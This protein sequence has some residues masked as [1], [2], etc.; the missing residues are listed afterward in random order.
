MRDARHRGGKAVRE[1]QA[2]A[3]LRSLF[4]SQRLAVL[5]TQRDGR[6]YGSLV[7]FEVSDDLK[8]LVFATARTTRK[9]ANLLADPWVALVIDSR[10]NRESDFREAV[11]VTATGLSREVF[12][13]EREALAGRYLAKHPA[14]REFV[15]SPTCAVVAVQVTTY[16]LVSRFEDVV[17]VPMRA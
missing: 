6:P 11:A 12:G 3:Q 8:Q 2:E 13:T 10:D 16:Y 9:F 5:S 1:D 7:A 4:S 14:L 17:E 15:E